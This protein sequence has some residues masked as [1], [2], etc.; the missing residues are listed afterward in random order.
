V[1][2]P[3]TFPSGRARDIVCFGTLSR[4]SLAA[5]GEA[6]FELLG[7]SAG[8]AASAA[9]VHGARVGI[10]ARVGRDLPLEG[11]NALRRIGVDLSGIVK[12]DASSTRVELEYQGEEATK[13]TVTEGA[14]SG[15][16]VGDIPRAFMSAAVVHLSPVPIRAQIAVAAMF[17]GLGTIVALDPHWDLARAERKQTAQLLSLVDILCLN[18]RE[19]G[20]L[21]S[22]NR[23]REDT[24]REL[25]AAGPAVIVMT[26]GGAGA[27][28][29]ASE[30]V[31]S[32]PAI[33]PTHIDRFVGAGDT[34][35]GSFLAKLVQ[36]Y[37]L[38]D[39]AR[40]AAASAA[41]RLERVGVEHPIRIAC[42]RQKLA[43][44]GSD[45]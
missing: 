20:M 43:S 18:E 16:D 15:I 5:D 6:A 7:G 41:C 22:P 2:L 27:I 29:S 26:R 37:H 13:V 23:K 19:A 36:G 24:L 17:R 38:E 8:Y 44:L 9:A 14:S 34:F 3:L 12:C 40:I 33:P 21:T 35:H 42:V 32:V 1:L 45:L 39:A 11:L 28:V 4:D 31:H 25:H 10:V 30:R